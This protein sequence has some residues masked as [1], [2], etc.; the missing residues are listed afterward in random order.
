MTDAGTSS[1]TI[2]KELLKIGHAA[3]VTAACRNLA[4]V[5]KDDEVTKLQTTRDWYRA[6]AETYIYAFS[7]IPRVNKPVRLICKAC[8]AYAPDT[9]VGAIA[10]EWFERRRSLEPYVNTPRIYGRSG[11]TWIEEWVPHELGRLLADPSKQ[12]QIDTVLLQIAQYAGALSGLGFAAIEPFADLRSHGED[13]VAIDFGQDLGSPRVRAS[14]GRHLVDA[15]DY[16][17]KLG[18]KLTTDQRRQ[19]Y[20][21]FEV[22]EREAQLR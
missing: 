21:R 15:I 22:T 11:A 14:Q 7:V 18:V 2:E 17:T 19:M 12:V 3:Q 9:S 6:G 5:G 10:D 20:A 8:V 16:V 13:V 1:W 4:I